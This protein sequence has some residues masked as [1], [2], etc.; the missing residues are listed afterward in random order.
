LAYKKI[1]ETDLLNK[2]VLG[3]PD[4]PE[5]SAVEMQTK[6]EEVA[7]EVIIPAFNLL[8]DALVA[9]MGNIYTKEEVAQAIREKVV[10]VGTGDMAMYVY[11]TDGDGKVDYS[12]FIISTSGSNFTTLE[13]SVTD[14]VRKT[15]YA[16][17][18]AKIVGYGVPDY[19]MLLLAKEDEE[20]A[21]N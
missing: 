21:S 8:I 17:N 13:G 9:D 2:G 6:F 18:N 12:G 3:L 20:R 19:A 11:D 7:R 15:T 10:E 16:T 4:T 14:N 5:L 1:T